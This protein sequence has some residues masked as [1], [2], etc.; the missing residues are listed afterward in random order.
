MRI[1]NLTLPLYP[2]MPVGSVWAWDSPFQKHAITTV[3]SHGVETYQMTFHSET[4]TRLMLGACYD[5]TA[6]RVDQLDYAPFVNRD[7]VIIDIPKGER[8]EISP[9]DI[10]RTVAVD[11]DFCDGDAVLIRTGWGD[12]ERYRHL[13]DDYAILTPHFSVAGAERLIEVMQRKH[14]DVM[15]TDCAYIGNAG[16]RFM[17]PEW[18][19][20]APWDRPPFPSQQARIYMRHYTRARGAGG[21]A[22]DWA[23]SV[24]LHAALSP[25]AALCNCGALRSKRVKITLLPLFLEGAAGAPCSVIAIEE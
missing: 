25:I 1:T 17:Y 3:D 4:G 16:E 24:P 22:P 21:G 7:T 6:P 14:S 20:R 13:G 19:S 18:A 9:E 12:N 5:E 23:A 15:F 2:F 10:D 8:E 11:P